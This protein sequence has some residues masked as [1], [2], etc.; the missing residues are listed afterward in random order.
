MGPRGLS[1]EIPTTEGYNYVYAPS[2]G[3]L[4]TSPTRRWANQEYK[5]NEANTFRT[6]FAELRALNRAAGHR[7]RTVA[8]GRPQF[9]LPW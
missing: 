2:W 4:R 3:R 6:R 1:N 5:V 9:H 8:C 7:T